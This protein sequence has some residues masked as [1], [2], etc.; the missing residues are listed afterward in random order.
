MIDKENYVNT[1][2]ELGDDVLTDALIS[3]VFPEEFSGDFIDDKIIKVAPYSLYGCNAVINVYFPLV[4]IAQG[5]CFAYNYYLQS[6]DLPECT[7]VAQSAFQHCERL[8]EV[9]LP[10]VTKLN[11][12]AFQYCKKLQEIHLPEAT[13]V[14]SYTFGDC[15]EL[16]VVDLPK[17]LRAEG[18]S[19]LNCKKL[20]TVILPAATY[21]VA[22]FMQCPVLE[23]VYLPA[24]T[25]LGT[26]CFAQA[27]ALQEVNLGPNITKIDPNAFNQTPT[28]MVINIP[29]EEGVISGAPWGGINATINYAHPY[30]GPN[31]ET[32]TANE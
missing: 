5:S 13:G 2:D 11:S 17:V 9:N 22:P 8:L 6:A 23:K 25:Q 24:I 15:W 7:E 12:N 10:K 19:F 18:S 1:L 32:V 14:P 3:R 29:V 4:T 20:K 31:G 26:N 30:V 21:I 28:G 16:E 27:N